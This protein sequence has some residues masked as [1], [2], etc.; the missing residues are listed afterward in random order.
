[1]IPELALQIIESHGGDALRWPEADRASLLALA[2]VDAS[3]GAALAEARALDAL[4]T[5][6]AGNAAP[7]SFDLAAITR[8][9]QEQVARPRRWLAG[10]A[11]GAAAAAAL[12]VLAPMAGNISTPAAVPSAVASNQGIGGEVIGSDGSTVDAEAF[13]EVF[14]PTA[15]E[16]DL[17]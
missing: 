16:E 5:D 8:T 13:A 15:D 11:L 9:P 6:W 10:G 17:I 4:L 14:T 2:A 1:V 7:A 3:V 12:I